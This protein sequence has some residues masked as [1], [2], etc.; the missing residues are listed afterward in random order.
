M[1]IP[2]MNAPRDRNHREA[3]KGVTCA[4]IPMNTRAMTAASSPVDQTIPDLFV[5]SEISP[6]ARMNPPKSSQKPHTS[7]RATISPL[8]SFLDTTGTSVQL[9][10]INHQEIHP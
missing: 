10:H 5:E 6:V 2:P 3:S 9:N 4:P 1:T 7:P 8:S